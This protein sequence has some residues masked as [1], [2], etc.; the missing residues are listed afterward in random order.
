MEFNTYIATVLTKNNTQ[1]KVKFM[2]T[3]L[4]DAVDMAMEYCDENK[5]TQIIPITSENPNIKTV[6][7]MDLSARMDKDY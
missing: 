4:Y 7:T 3:G 2:A 1:E 6:M 5:C